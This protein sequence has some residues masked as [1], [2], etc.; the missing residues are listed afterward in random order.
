MTL[1]IDDSAAQTRADIRF[2]AQ[3]LIPVVAQEET[4]GEVLLLA[5][6]NAEAL[7]LTVAEGVLVLW[8]RSRG[9][10]WRKGEQSGNTLRLSELRLNCEGNSLLARVRLEGVAA[11]HEGYRTCY[12]RRLDADSDNSTAAVGF[13]AALIEPRVFDPAEIYG[14]PITVSEDAAL[15]R[16]LRLLYVAYEQLRD[17][18]ERPESGTSRR[19]HALDVAAMAEQSLARS[20]EELEELRGVVAGTHRH[21]GGTAD[22]ILEAGQVEYWALL[23]AVGLGHRYDE[24]QPHLAWRSRRQAPTVSAGD[25]TSH[26]VDV[27]V[28]QRCA[29]LIADAGALCYEAE[30]HPAQVVAADLAAMWA[31]YPNL[32]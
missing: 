14:D 5:Y 10:L 16:D 4:T 32:M 2:D 21:R 29:A 1:E 27:G 23:A 31:R 6:M 13:V 22:V 28:L 8:S 24:W 18:A 15:E 11:C 30:V 20:R 25:A 19:L 7:R 12:F 26:T 3:G 9:K 17:A